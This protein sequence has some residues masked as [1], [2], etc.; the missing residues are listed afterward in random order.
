MSSKKKKMLDFI[1]RCT[2]TYSALLWCK[3]F[4]AHKCKHS[5]QDFYD[6]KFSVKPIQDDGG[7]KGP[8]NHFCPCSFYRRYK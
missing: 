5:F 4:C 8:P 7:Q 2:N 1:K 3:N 6:I